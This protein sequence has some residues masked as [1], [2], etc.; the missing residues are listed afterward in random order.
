MS[1]FLGFKGHVIPSLIGWPRFFIRAPLMASKL[2][3]LRIGFLTA[4]KLLFKFVDKRGFIITSQH[5]L[6]AYWDF[7]VEESFSDSAWVDAFIKSEHP[8]AIDVGA[9]AGIFT[10][11]LSTLNPK[12]E[13]YAF[14]PLPDMQERIARIQAISRCEIHII[15][16]ACGRMNGDAILCANGNDDTNAYLSN[17]NNTAYEAKSSQITVQVLPIDAVVPA[18]EVILLKIDA[19]SYEVPVLEG[20]LHTLERTCHLIVEVNSD[21]DLTSIKNILGSRWHG[22]PLTSNDYIFSRLSDL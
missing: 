22:C 1:F 8:V 7:F 11:Y 4:R 13:I 16:A 18:G 19:E 10:Y 14:E 17:V 20:A 3:A 15:T 21:H 5:E 2:L 9:N 12:A 6:V